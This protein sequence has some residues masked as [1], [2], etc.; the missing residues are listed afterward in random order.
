MNCR[1]EQADALCLPLPDRSV[2]LVFGSP[3]YPEKGE[4]YGDSARRWPSAEWARWMVDATREALRVSR[5]PVC[6]VVNGAVRDGRYLPAVE[7]LL[8]ALDDAGIHLER[9]CIWHKNAPPNRRDWFGNDWE[10]I[11]CA[12]HPGPVPYFDWQAVGTPPKYTNGGRFRQRGSNGARRL[13]GEYRQNPVTRPRDVFRV[14]VG[15]G[16]LGSPLAHENEAPFPEA[17]VEPLILALCPPGGVVLDPFC[18]SG[19]TLAVALRAG[20]HAVGFDVR[21]SQVALARRRAATV[22]VQEGTTPC[23]G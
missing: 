14:T 2:D 21:E 8:A 9:P 18:G 22:E 16:H 6:W 20:R 23:P 4:R 19:T 11:V 3:P 10:Y 1:I 5:G 17:L 15:G 13:G 7:R 12:K